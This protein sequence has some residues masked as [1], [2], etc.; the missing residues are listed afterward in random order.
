MF[1]I[2]ILLH[3]LQ[4]HTYI[5]GEHT[6]LP[7]I[8]FL[9]SLSCIMMYAESPFSIPTALVKISEQNFQKIIN[10]NRLFLLKPSI[11]CDRQQHKLYE[12]NS[13]KNS[14]FFHL[15]TIALLQRHPLYYPALFVD[16]YSL[17]L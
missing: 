1:D 9:Q 6:D 15:F 5:R 2:V 14:L 11:V 8:S 13:I 17:R 4:L 7:N 3:H 16:I 12:F 10:S